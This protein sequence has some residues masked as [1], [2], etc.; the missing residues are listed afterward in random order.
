MIVAQL[1]FDRNIDKLQVFID[2]N[3]LMLDCGWTVAVPKANAVKYFENYNTR[4]DEGFLEHNGKVILSHSA[5]KI[6]LT[7]EEA[8]AILELIHETHM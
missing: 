8:S 7:K 2:E 4:P 5:S 1:S 6:Y 3:G